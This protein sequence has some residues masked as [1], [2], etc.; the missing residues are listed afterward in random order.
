MP[1]KDRGNYMQGV[2]AGTKLMNVTMYWHTL[3]N[4]VSAEA[5]KRLPPLPPFALPLEIFQSPKKPTDGE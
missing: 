1:D 5:H 4:S 2:L 3:F